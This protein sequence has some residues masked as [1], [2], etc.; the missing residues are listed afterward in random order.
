MT[1]DLANRSFSSLSFFRCIRFIGH[2]LGN[3]GHFQGKLH[4]QAEGTLRKLQ[5]RSESSL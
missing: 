4:K 1:V 5:K 3:S 2:T